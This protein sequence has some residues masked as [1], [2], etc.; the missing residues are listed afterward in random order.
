MA[1]FLGENERAVADKAHL[2]NKNAPELRELVERELAHNLADLGTTLT[3]IFGSEKPFA[4]V[5]T[6]IN[7]LIE[8][9]AGIVGVDNYES[10]TG[11]GGGNNSGTWAGSG[12]ASGGNTTQ[13]TT[14]G[15]NNTNKNTNKN[16]N[17]DKQ[18][19]KSDRYTFIDKKSSYSKDK[20]KKNIET[21][22]VDRLKYYDK[23]SS[24]DA[25][26][27]Y[28]SDLGGS[29]TYTGS[30]TQN[31]WLIS[32]MKEN[33]FA[34]GGTIGNLIKRTGEDGFVLARTGEEIL[35]LE[36]IE[37]LRD[38]FENINPAMPNLNLTKVPS[39][40]RR[41]IAQNVSLGGITI[42]QVVANNPQEFVQ[43]LKTVMSRDLNVQK[44]VQEISFGQGLGNNTMNVKKYM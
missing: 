7:N 4:S 16:A 32:K 14:Q 25:R 39:I 37:A 24:W 22:I 13:G 34:Q 12:S 27:K 2:A 15:T 38:I 17:T 31:K 40:Q 28:Y 10:G 43:Q 3:S 26:A 41:D 35:S 42:E 44:M 20:L 23:D 9:I 19:E 6:A 1:F 30:T 5:E 18:A 36:K 8:K 11:S 21:S 33:G 29:G